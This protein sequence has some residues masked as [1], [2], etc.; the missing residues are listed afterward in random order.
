MFRASFLFAVCLFLLSRHSM[1]SNKLLRLGM[2]KSQVNETLGAPDIVE[3]TSTETTWVYSGPKCGD[4]TK[5]CW[6]E[7]KGGKL[8]SQVRIGGRYLDLEE[9]WPEP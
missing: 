4:V 9:E 3:T 1:A 6:L 7:F 2:P 5:R 8:T